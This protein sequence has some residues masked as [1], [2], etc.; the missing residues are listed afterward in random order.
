[1]EAFNA[2]CSCVYASAMDEIKYGNKKDEM[3]KRGWEK[4]RP[5]TKMGY[6][7]EDIKKLTKKR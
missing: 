4:S 7:K 2:K 5:Q 6:E 3:N 1:M